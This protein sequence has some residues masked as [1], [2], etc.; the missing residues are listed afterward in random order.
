MKAFAMSMDLDPDFFSTAHSPDLAPSNVLRL[1]K[2]PALSSPPDR[3][4]PRLGEHTDWGTLTLLFAKTAGLEVKSPLNGWVPAPIVDGAV[5]V[6][7]ADGLSLWSDKVLKSTM[8][9]LPW[10]SLP[11][12]LDLFSMAY[13]VNANAVAPLKF[14][15]RKEGKYV[16]ADMPFDATFGDYQAV[17][18]RIIHEKF[19]SDEKGEGPTL[20]PKFVDIVRNLGVAHG[21]GLTFEGA[22]MDGA[23]EITVN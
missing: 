17:R 14:L 20:D 11:F 19:D 10:D 4:F 1:I 9:R 2:Y 15:T 3:R 12:D 16:E 8:H 22:E 5:I 13:F 6:N 21:N 23:T 18:M 7:I